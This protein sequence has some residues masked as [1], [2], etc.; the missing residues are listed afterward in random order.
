M[1]S[2]IEGIIASFSY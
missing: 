1:D 2:Y